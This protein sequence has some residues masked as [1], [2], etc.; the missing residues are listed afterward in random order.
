MHGMGFA[1]PFRMMQ[2][3]DI[4][5]SE[6]A[7][8]T[9][10][11]CV[12]TY[13]RPFIEA[14]LRSLDAQI[15][16]ADVTARIIV[17]DN[18]ETPS[19]K[20]LV[21][22][23]AGTLSI[24]VTYIHAPANNISIARNAGLEEAKAEWIAFIDDDEEAEPDWL[25]CLLQTAR[26]K[27]L[28]AVFGPAMA[29]YPDDAPHWMRK[30][31]YH[32][33]IPQRRGGVVQ[34][35][36]TCNALLRAS[37]SLVRGQRFLLEKGKTGGEDTEFFFRLWFNGAK[38]DITEAAI[39]HEKVDPKRMNLDWIRNRKFRSGM[40][41]GYHSLTTRNAVTL[42][43]AALGAMAKISICYIMAGLFVWSEEKRNYWLLRAMFHRGVLAS[44]SSKAEPEL[45]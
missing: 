17:I 26:L 23:V 7:E 35:G 41:Y 20:A 27:D 22:Q 43:L 44:T 14:T 5:L 24:P 34:T 18:D 25:A 19:A 31:D 42:T 30:Q 28:D 15:L 3:V 33:N 36:H 2:G 4:P 21:D 45:Y 37:S 12:C 13:R 10:D 6:V 29:E 39:V 8:V 16:P 40:S 1:D 38:L 9:I 32:S 11:I